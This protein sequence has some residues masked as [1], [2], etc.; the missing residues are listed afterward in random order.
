MTKT[1]QKLMIGIT[2]CIA[3]YCVSAVCMTGVPELVTF[4]TRENQK[5]TLYVQILPHELFL[6]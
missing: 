4:L 2:W 1:V 6:Y 5:E 3:K